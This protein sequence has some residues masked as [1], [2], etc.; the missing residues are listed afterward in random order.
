MS[1]T[2]VQLSE[3]FTSFQGEGPYLGVK[4]IFVRLAGCNLA[5]QYC[6]TPQGLEIAPTFKYEPV[7]GE[8]KI[9]NLKNS[10]SVSQLNE[11]IEKIVKNTGH[12]HSISLT[13]GEPLL[14]VGF[15]KN[16]LPAV[17]NI[18]KLPIYLETNGTLPD[19][20]AEII[21]LIDIVALDFKLP[22]ASGGTAYWKEHA[23]ALETAYL[24]ELFVKVVFT[25]ETKIKEIEEAASLVAKIDNNIPFILQ[26][27]T[28][29]GPIKHRP[30]MEE[31]LAFHNI[32]SRQLKNV[33]VIPQTHK[34]MGIA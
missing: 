2:E 1:S 3:I 14:Q 22:S 17:K 8:K 16:W 7:P 26:P 30:G 12:L 10:L 33:R 20:L 19:Y 4:Q 23:K 28:P 31:I 13:G 11:L 6:D 15:I 21:E 5:C 34:L 24:K 25:K 29:H 32:A 27:V 9:E 18:I